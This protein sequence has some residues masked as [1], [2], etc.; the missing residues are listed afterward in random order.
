MGS[1][2]ASTM[3][4]RTTSPWEVAP[5]ARA[6]AAGSVS[7]SISPS[8]TPTVA[9]APLGID[10][11]YCWYAT[12]PSGSS[13]LATI[14]IPLQRPGGCPVATRAGRPPGPVQTGPPPRLDG[15]AVHLYLGSHGPDVFL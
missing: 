2:G 6:K 8:V 14:D 7:S 1:W 10:T 12:A 13:L 9:I 4:T 5:R 3:P 11:S 15:I